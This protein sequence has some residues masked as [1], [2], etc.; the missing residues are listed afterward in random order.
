[1]AGRVQARLEPYA[2]V[3][4]AVFRVVFGALFCCHGL[5]K[6]LGWPAAT[7]V[8]VGAWP[9]YYAGWIE[10][11]TGVLIVAGLFTRLAAAIACAEMVVAYFTR[12]LPLGLVPLTNKGELA[13]LYGVAFLL[14]VF[15]GAGAYGLDTRRSA[16]DGS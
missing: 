4:V 14:L 8:P 7:E 1:M 6:L 16:G 3:A 10:L 2:P 12:H 15:L 9:L 13:V 11:V 5:S